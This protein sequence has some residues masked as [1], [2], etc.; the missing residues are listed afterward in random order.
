VEAHRNAPVWQAILSFAAID[1]NVF[2]VESFRSVQEFLGHNQ[3]SL[4]AL[5]S[6]PVQGDLSGKLDHQRAKNKSAYSWSC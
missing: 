4:D 5:D 2:D 6:H 1:W 3:Q